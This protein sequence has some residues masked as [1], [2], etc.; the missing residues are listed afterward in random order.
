MA[1]LAKFLQGVAGAGGAALNVEDVFSTYLY[2]GNGSTQ[3]ITN[4]IDLSGE[5]GLVWGINRTTAFGHVLAT[6]EFSAPNYL[7]SHSTGL[8]NTTASSVTSF[9]SDGFDVGSLGDINY[10]GHDFVSWTFRKAPKFFD[11]VT[12][13]GNGTAGRTVSHN[14]G[15]V[16]GMMIIK[17]TDSGAAWYV[18]HREMSN[19]DTLRL[20]TNAAKSTNQANFLN[21]TTPTDTEFTLG[22]EAD[23]NGSGGTFIAYLFAHNDGDGDFGPDG[24]ADIIKC[25]SLTTDGSGYATADLGFEPQFVLVKSTTRTEDWHLLDTMRGLGSTGLSNKRL[26]ANGSNSEDTLGADYFIIDA[27][28]FKINAWMTNHTYIYIAIRRGPM[29]VPE[30]ATD[31]FAVDQENSSAPYYTSNFPV[32]MGFIRRKDNTSSWYIYDRLRQGRELVINTTAAEGGAGNA[33]FDYMDGFSEGAFASDVYSWMWKRAPSYF[34]VVA[35]SGT[36]SARNLSHNLG[37]APEMMWIKPRDL[38]YQWSVYHKD[39]SSSS[40]YYE[41]KLNST[42]ALANSG[43]TNAPF[44][45]NPT[46]TTIPLPSGTASASNRS[47]YNYIAYLFASVAGVSKVGSYT[48]NGSTQNIDCGFSSGARFVLI[49]RTDNSSDWFVFDSERGINA[50]TEPRLELNNTDAEPTAT[51]QIDPYSAGFNLASQSSFNINISGASYIFYA[52][53]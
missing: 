53:A 14:L 25:G 13:T 28:S 33:Q 34:D 41:L 51:D 15:S 39:V 37:V 5:G 18:Y 26:R 31:V 52:I 43:N 17:R 7:K 46:A 10:N 24:D 44:A 35:Y 16:P 42:D 6:T 22:S 12:Y 11:V 20:N 27:T 23:V 50:G 8:L 47:G 21:S 29:A 49:K 19:T 45:G 9:N 2:E 32:D 48:G 30:S 4:G 1:K 38:S 40:P 3:T 36:G